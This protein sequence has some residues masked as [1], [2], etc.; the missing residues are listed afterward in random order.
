MKVCGFSFVRNGVK[1]DYPFTE[2]I[3]SVLPLCDKFILAV[4]KSDDNTLEVAKAIDPNK[5]EILE[6]VWDDTL[7]TGG[8]VF[9]DETNKA[10]RAIPP[11][12]DWAFYIQADEVLHEQY[13]NV[14]QQ[15]MEHWLHVH[16][17]EGLLFNYLH[18]F[19]SYD[20]VGVKHSWYRREIRIVRNRKD[21][22][23]YRDAQGFRKKPNRKLQ[24]KLIDAFIYHYGHVRDPEAMKAKQR[25]SALL[26]HAGN[27]GDAVP[28]NFSYELLGEPVMRFQGTHPA[29]MKDRIARKNWAFQPDESLRY[30]SFKDW[31][32]RTVARYTG[33][34]P[35]EY[36]NYR[37]LR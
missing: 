25:S 14:V 11:E 23:S 33:W 9:A 1:F 36:R 21:I 22:F 24:V 7:K 2:A 5:V 30:A 12:Y 34:H 19:G 8:R 16:E 4:G 10:F 3:R 17:V 37:I 18:F 32:K 35:F 15:E 27:E 31:F 26:Y 28:D 29:V 20:F 13:L 6:T